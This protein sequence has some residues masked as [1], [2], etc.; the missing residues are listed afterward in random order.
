VEDEGFELDYIWIRFFY[1]CWVGC[2]VKTL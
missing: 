1:V 2:S